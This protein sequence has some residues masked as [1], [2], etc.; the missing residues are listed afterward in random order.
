MSVA[1]LQQQLASS[2]A[3]DVELQPYFTALCGSIGASMIRDHNQLTLDVHV[4]KSTTTADVSVSLGLIV[5]ELVIN[6]LKHAFPGDRSGKI[7]VDYSAHGPNWMLSVTDNGIGMP[8]D[9]ALARPGLGT[10]IVEALSRQLKGVLKVTDANPGT[11]VSLTHAQ[12][13]IV[14]SAAVTPAARAV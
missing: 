5:T 2:S 3:S 14:E 4:D 13:A 7:K 1:A 9:A 6:A 12:I 8:K 11:I 10:S